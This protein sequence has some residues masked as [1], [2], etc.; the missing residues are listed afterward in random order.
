MNTCEVQITAHPE[1]P[2][3]YV[4]TYRSGFLG[5]AYSVEF[6]NTITGAVALYHFVEMLRTRHPE[7][8]VTFVLPANAGYHPV[9]AVQD[10]L[11]MQ[12]T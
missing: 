1:K 5:A 9:P 11:S 3:W 12:H 2:N 10:A 6:P 8:Q 4:A 7:G